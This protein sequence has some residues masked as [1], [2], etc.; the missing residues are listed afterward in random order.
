MRKP[1]AGLRRSETIAKLAFWNGP[2]FLGQTWVVFLGEDV[3][4]PLNDAQLKGWF[5]KGRGESQIA[6][7][8]AGKGS[9]GN[10]NILKNMK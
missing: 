4:L 10:G 1:Y 3:P 6:N 7:V 9:S 2:P 8:E 5:F